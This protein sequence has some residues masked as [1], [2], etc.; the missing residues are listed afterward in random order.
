MSV[1][2][3]LSNAVNVQVTDGTNAMPTG[4]S[5]SRPLYVALGGVNYTATIASDAQSLAVTG[6]VVTSAPAVFNGASWDRARTPNT[7]K[8]AQATASGDT[9]LWTPTSGKKFRLMRFKV[10]VTANAYIAARG[11]LTIKLRDAT[12]DISL[13]H[14]IY[15]G[16]TAIA[17]DTNPNQQP[18]LETGWIDLG[19]GFLSA[20]ANNVLNINLSAAL[21]GG[22]VRVTC[23]GTEE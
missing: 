8:T 1:T 4:D 15:L 22:N 7:F 12:T 21:S 23:A 5:S 2:P 6:I 3:P 9:A 11:V 16:Q 20:A 18:I 10:Q 17:A 13:T 19:N 14:D